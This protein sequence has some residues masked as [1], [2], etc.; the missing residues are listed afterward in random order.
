M[1]NPKWTNINS[2]KKIIRIGRLQPSKET[3]LKP[4]KEVDIVN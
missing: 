4:F 2:Q 3:C 1:K